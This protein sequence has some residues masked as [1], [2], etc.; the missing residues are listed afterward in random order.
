ME[1]QNLD[2]ED[3]RNIFIEMNYTI[4]NYMKKM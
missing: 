3:A 2:F 1:K 4:Q